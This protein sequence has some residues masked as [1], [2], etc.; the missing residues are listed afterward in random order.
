MGLLYLLPAVY[1]DVV[2]SI[3]Y[4]TLNANTVTSALFSFSSKEVRVAGI[5]CRITTKTLT[6][7]LQWQ[8]L[9]E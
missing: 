8:T 4:E 6:T 9:P 2:W 3:G 7:C 1:N 5:Y